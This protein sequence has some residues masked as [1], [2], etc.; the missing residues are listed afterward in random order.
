[1]EAGARL[2]SGVRIGPFCHVHEGATLHDGVELKSHVTVFGGTSIGAG[3]VVWPNAVLGGA[4]QNFAH[5]GGPS[6]LEIGKG[7]TIREG[8]SINRG[9]DGSRGVTR[10]GDNGY[11]MAYS[12]IAHDCIVG[13]RVVMANQA[14]LAGHCEVGDNVNIGGLTAVHQFVRI[15]H[16]AFIGGCS[17]LAGDV[18]PYGMAVGNRATLRGFNIVGMKRAGMA[19]SEIHELRRAYRLI[20]EGPGSMAE[21]AAAAA[22]TFA[23]NALVAEIAAFIGARG[24]RFFCVPE[25]GHSGDDAPAEA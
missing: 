23:D 12:H 21:N 2:G 15:G 17:G 7:C 9:T 10:V 6:T 22:G 11:F 20:F 1:M 14:T 25:R 18:I 4:P 13:N 8:V 16:H 19:R 24:R 5:K 3:T